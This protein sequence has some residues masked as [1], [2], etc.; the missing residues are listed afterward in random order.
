MEQN[1]ELTLAWQ[2]IENTGTHLFLTGKAGTGKTTFLRK[3]KRESPKRMV[4]IAPTGIAAINAGG[5]TIH[6]FFQI[7]F[8]PYVPESSFS[9]NG[10]ATY[11]FRFGKEKINIIRS[12]DLLVI[13]EISMVRADLLDAVDEMLRRYRDRHKPFGG[14]QL[15]MIG[16]L[17]QLAP[18]VKDEEW[19]MLKKYYDTPY[20]FSSRALKQT[21]YCTIELKTV[22]R[23]SDGAFLDLL[24]RIRENHC[25]PQVL[26]ALNRRYLPDFQPRKEEGYIRLV[27]HNYQAQRINNY[28]L[29][30]LPGRSYAFRATIDGKFPEYSYPTD[31]L[32]ELKKGA[33]VMFVK[34]DSS[35]E[36]RYYNGMIGE[37][38]D[39]SADSIEVRAKD[40]TVAF[41]L[42]EEEWA[43]AKYVL[44]EES[45]EIVEDIEGTFRQFPLKLAWAITIHKSQGLTFER[46]IIDASSSFAHG[47]TYVALSR[48]KTLEGLVLSA[49][50]SAKAVISD[51]AVDRF[52]E[53]ARR[54]EP[55][56]DRFHSLQRTYF[57]ELLSGLFDFRPLEQSLQRY[58]RLIDEHLYKLYPKQLAA[59]K[60]EAE[61][62]HEKVVIVAQ[63]FGM[64]YN[65]LIDAAQNYATDETLQ[66]RIAAGAG[67]FKKEMEPQYLV[68]IKE[69]VLATDNK[70]L[71]KQLNTAKE[72]LNTLFLLKDDLLA[73]VI[74]HGFRTAEYLRQ[75]AILSIGDSALSGKEDL[76]RRGLL[77]AV[78][79]NIRER[80]K[81]E[82]AT[83]AVQVP[84]DVLHPELYD[85]LVAWRNSEASRLGLPVYTVIQQKAILGISNLLPA[86]KAM[87][88]RIPYFGKKGV[89]KYGDIILEMVH[90]YRKEK[91]LAEPELML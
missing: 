58:V 87:L 52:T 37:V 55:D 83:P 88:V 33:Q 39:L 14:V 2:F 89:E 21:E 16:D 68:L 50:L 13:D 57:H 34:N 73:Y 4:V 71:K 91:G 59:Y 43:N 15:L 26:E 72:E 45:K 47:Q 82:S 54:N 79:K 42:Q 75:K 77:D 56:E 76:K 49:P 23:Q 32:L 27:T 62:F 6:S 30:Q 18:V 24:N 9:T 11:R 81:K 61:R 35:G 65:R 8:A 70:E 12:M 1:S 19:Q 67:Y 44:D 60:A 36:H 64:Q 85:R 63:K 20:F 17:Q 90:G 80:K 69:R 5:V 7:P 78:E 31:E 74:A 10:Q 84:S 29:E 53:E 48:C 22:Y 40:S 41:L 38:T 66:E 86:D 28:E 3:L 25:D 46:A 51:R